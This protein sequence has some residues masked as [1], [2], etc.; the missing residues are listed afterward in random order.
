MT[1]FMTGNTHVFSAAFDEM[2]RNFGPG[3]DGLKNVCRILCRHERI[4]RAWR[5]GERP[6]P[7]WAYELLRLTYG[8]RCQQ[9]EHM[10]GGNRML[11]N[12]FRISMTRLSLVLGDIHG[13]VAANDGFK[14]VDIAP[15]EFTAE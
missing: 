6:C 2:C 1:K 7:K 9:L 15:G 12:A 11:R 5:G 10:T 4:V 14:V 13:R 8:E 3:S